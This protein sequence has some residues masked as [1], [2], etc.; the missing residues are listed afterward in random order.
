VHDAVRRRKK[1]RPATRRFRIG[2][3]HNVLQPAGRSAPAD[4]FHFCKDASILLQF[5]EPPTPVRQQVEIATVIFSGRSPAGTTAFAFLQIRFSVANPG[6]G[7]RIH[8]M[9]ISQ[10]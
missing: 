7:N 9:L 2:L 1:K 6:C 3:N 5:C 10:G 8:N 4:H